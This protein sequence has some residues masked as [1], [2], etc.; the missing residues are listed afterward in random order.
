MEKGSPECAPRAL[1]PYPPRSLLLRRWPRKPERVADE[2]GVSRDNYSGVDQP[3]KSPWQDAL[4]TFSIDVDTASYSNV[5][6]FMREGAAAASRRRAYRGAGELLR[7]RLPRAHRAIVPFSVYCRGLATARGTRQHRLVHL[8]LQG[9][10][11]SRDTC[12][13]RNL[14]FLV[15]VSGSMQ[16][17]NK[18]PCSKQGL[19]HAG[20]HHLRPERSRGHRG[21]CGRGRVCALPSTERTQPGKDPRRASAL[22]KRG[23]RTNGAAG[24]ELAYDWRRSTSSRAA[25]TA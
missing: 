6:R 23:A 24:I 14:V 12:P 19:H 17:P 2:D 1:T 10:H 4:S 3:R 5:R 13:P 20:A 16:D 22:S 8:G 15:D 21:L 11:I 18:L 25:S 7:L 9:K